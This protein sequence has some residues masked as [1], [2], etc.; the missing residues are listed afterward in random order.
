MF[1][2]ELMLTVSGFWNV[3]D[4]DDSFELQTEFRLKFEKEMVVVT[5]CRTQ[6]SLECAFRRHRTL[7]LL[8]EK[9]LQR[10]IE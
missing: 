6:V 1:S 4:I 2:F 5:G 10:N 8:Q 3:K 9:D 7:Q